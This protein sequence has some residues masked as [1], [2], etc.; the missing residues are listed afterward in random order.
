MLCASTLLPGRLI[1]PTSSF[2]CVL[3]PR[4]LLM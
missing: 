2:V 4:T 1:S 3:G